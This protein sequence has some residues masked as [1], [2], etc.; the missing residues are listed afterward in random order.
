MPN[1]SFGKLSFDTAIHITGATH[2][3]NSF[4]V[5]PGCPLFVGSIS[6]T[7]LGAFNGSKDIV[8]AMCNNRLIYGEMWKIA[9]S[10]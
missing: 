10:C 8:S 5:I 1:V 9:Q 2:C 3:T 6:A 4:C 7:L